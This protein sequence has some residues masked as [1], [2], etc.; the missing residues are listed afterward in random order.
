MVNAAGPAAPIVQS[1]IGNGPEIGRVVCYEGGVVDQ[2]RCCNH[3]VDAIHNQARPQ[4]GGSYPA[5]RLGE[6]ILKRQ[7]LNFLPN[8]LI[9]DGDALPQCRR[10]DRPTRTVPPGRYL[11]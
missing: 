9:Q 5:K 8:K 7:Y 10:A 1:Q 11:E 6:A 2:G 4:E 3:Q